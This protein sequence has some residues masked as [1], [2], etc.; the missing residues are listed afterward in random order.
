VKEITSIIKAY[1][2]A[3]QDKKRMALATVV[4][5]EGSSY[6]RP[7]A[8]MLVT[9]DGHMTGAISGGCLE[10]D[11]LR[12]A[13]MAIAQGK[14]KLVTYD[15]SDESDVNLGAQIGCN[16]IVHILFEPI[17]PENN[18]NPI[19][20]LEQ[21]Y[22]QRQEA[23]VVTLFNLDAIYGNQLG[24]CFLSL[25]HGQPAEQDPLKL[26]AF[27]STK[28]DMAFQQKESIFTPL[29]IQQKN[30]TAFVEYIPSPVSVVIV[31]A[32]NDS[33]PIVEMATIL[34]WET[35]VIDGRHSHATRRRFPLAKEIHVS[36]AEDILTK[37][38]PDKRTFFILLT[39]N[40]Q[41][42]YLVLKQLIQVQN[43]PYIGALGPKKKLLRMYDD[44][45]KEGILVTDQ[46]KKS[47]YG[48]VGLELGAETSEEIALSILAEI[49]KVLNQTSGISL[50]DKLVPIHTVKN[51]Q[52]D[53][54]KNSP[55]SFLCA[56]QFP[57]L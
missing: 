39:H 51:I 24:T 22:A 34:G 46:Q 52:I 40:Y 18:Q 8:R 32:G 14:N 4:H 38:S 26:K 27:L 30:W 41:Y 12:K 2:N 35:T 31:G 11:A 42:D 7:G 36:K 21:V 47:I 13:I 49:K 55:E 17:D 50:R 53:Y 15:T 33:I 16:G 5:V 6:R 9:E 10:G 57:D 37:I 43:L 23:V 29:D 19:A 54:E 48:P 44:L 45:E 3:L 28:V 1:T 25:Q 56:V 20:L